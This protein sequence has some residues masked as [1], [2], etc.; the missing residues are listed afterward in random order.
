M[1]SRS[2]KKPKFF[3]FSKYLIPKNK[4]IYA[5][6]KKMADFSQKILIEIAKIST[7]YLLN[8]RVINQRFK[9]RDLIYVSDRIFAKNPHS[10]TDALV[11]IMKVK[12]NGRDCNI[13]ILDRTLLKRYFLDIVSASAT[14]SGLEV[15]L[16]DPFQLIN[17][18]DKTPPDHLY[19]KFKLFLEEFKRG[20]FTNIPRI[21]S[22]RLEDLDVQ[23]LLEQEN[24]DNETGEQ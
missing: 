20:E 21:I 12:E 3:T 11:K 6:I 17:W 4:E 5:Q 23:M 13:V 9:V 18:K 16:I 7:F 10:L 22:P 19:P 2:N 14:K 1:L 8:K 24:Q 15:E